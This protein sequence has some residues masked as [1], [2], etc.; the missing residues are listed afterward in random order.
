MSK[1]PHFFVWIQKKNVF[2]GAVNIRHHLNEKLLLE[3]GHI[4]YGVR[5]SCR[6][7]GI[8]TKMLELALIESKSLV[9][10]EKVL[11]VANSDNIGS[12]KCIL[13]NGGILENEVVV[14]EKSL[15]RYWISI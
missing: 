9:N 13:K 7:Q 11:L 5:P 6:K 15:R 1:I 14:D 12:I 10:D 8:A 2:V 3:A 4:G